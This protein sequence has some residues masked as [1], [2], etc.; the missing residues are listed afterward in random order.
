MA[1]FQFSGAQIL[2]QRMDKR[3]LWKIMNR[4]NV[5]GKSK[6]MQTRSVVATGILVSVA[7]AT[8]APSAVQAKEAAKTPEV[9]I[10]DPM[11]TEPLVR[12]GSKYIQSGMSQHRRVISKPRQGSVDIDVG[13]NTYKAGV[14]AD[15]PY[16]YDKD[17]L[18]YFARGDGWMRSNGEEVIARSGDLMWR[19]AG[20]VTENTRVLTD[21]VTICAFT[22]ARNDDWSHKL[23]DSEVGKWSGDPSKKPIVKWARLQDAV[24]MP[25]PGD[26]NYESGRIV[27]RMMLPAQTDGIKGADVTYTTYKAGTSVQGKTNMLEQIC[28]LDSGKLEVSLPGKTQ[29]LEATYFMYSPVGSRL[30][31]IKALQDSNLL[32]FTEPA[33]SRK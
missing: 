13:Y 12:G 8:I 33:S 14:G 4:S 26:A 23:P 10:L 3:A 27:E 11:Q 15:K 24:I 25:H 29:S 30:K 2:I 28:W 22:P 19:P 18:C 20:A 17:E 16:A 32:C 5:M 7:I 21:T 9:L 1:S 6:S 31:G